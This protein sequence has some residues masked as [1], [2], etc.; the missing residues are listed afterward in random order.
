MVCCNSARM[1]SW[2]VRA[3][4]AG[5]KSYS[6]RQTSHVYGPG[7]HGRQLRAS[8][9]PRRWGHEKSL[10]ETGPRNARAEVAR[11]EMAHSSGEVTP[12]SIAGGVLRDGVA[13]E[14]VHC[15]YVEC[16][17]R[18]RE[19]RFNTTKTNAV[20]IY[21]QTSYVLYRTKNVR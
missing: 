19:I 2:G 13:G 11:G 10:S 21:V 12:R 9:A 15:G 18:T 5:R 17:S 16:S 20:V 7:K 3:E 8:C 1:P 6:A 14:G 4:L